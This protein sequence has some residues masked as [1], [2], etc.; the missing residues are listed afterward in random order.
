[1]GGHRQRW[2]RPPSWGLWVGRSG[3]GAPPALGPALRGTAWTP[4]SL[5]ECS[6]RVCLSRPA[7]PPQ[8]G[9]VAAPEGGGFSEA[10]QTQPL[11][12]TRSVHGVGCLPHGT[13][14]RPRPGDLSSQPQGLR[15]LCASIVGPSAATSPA[16]PSP[17]V[18][19]QAPRACPWASRRRRCEV[20]GAGARVRGRR[21]GAGDRGGGCGS[22]ESGTTPPPPTPQSRRRCHCAGREGVE[23]AW[24]RHR[25]EGGGGGEGVANLYFTRS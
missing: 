1:M 6:W 12:V 7:L 19:F 4:G 13:P 9:A 20:S 24:A 11:S 16:A 23:A 14:S 15:F 22:Q 10:A 21:G 18:C 25:Q 3:C 8:T 5:Q 2:E 17:G